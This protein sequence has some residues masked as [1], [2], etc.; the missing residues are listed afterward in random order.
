M[1]QQNKIRSVRA[2]PQSSSPDLKPMITLPRAARQSAD[3]EATRSQALQGLSKVH[4]RTSGN[5]KC[6]WLLR[7][8]RH[9]QLHR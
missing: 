9:D 3:R 1:A 2:T 7:E 8:L 5:Q 4:E 6:I